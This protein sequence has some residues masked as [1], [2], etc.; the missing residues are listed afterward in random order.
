[1][2]KDKIVAHDELLAKVEVALRRAAKRARDRGADQHPDRCLRRRE[3]GQEKGDE[4][5]ERG[6]AR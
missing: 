5:I 3:S 4:E 2:K 6:Q 1:M